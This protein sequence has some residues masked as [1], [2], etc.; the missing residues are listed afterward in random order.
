MMVENESNGFWKD[1]IQDRVK[2]LIIV[3]TDFVAGYLDTRD[4]HFLIF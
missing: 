4:F 1:L 3:S 2:Q